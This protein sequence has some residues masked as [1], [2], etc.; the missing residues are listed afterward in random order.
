MQL[1][2]AHEMQQMDGRT[3]EAFGLPGRVLMENAG[4]G[5]VAYFARVFGDLNTKRVGVLAGRGNNGGDGFVMARYLA[6]QGVA[7]TVFLLSA[8]DRLQ[9]D[10]LTNLDLLTPLN[11]PVLE[12]PDADELKHRLPTLNAQ[13]IIIDALLGTGLNSDVRGF[14]KDV[15][16]WLNSRDKPVFAVDIPSGINADTGRICGVAV[17]ATATATFAFAKIGHWIYPGAAHCGA[18]YIVDIGIPPHIAAEVG[19]RQVG[20]TIRDV[21]SL[22][23]PRPM[24][25]HKGTTG[26]MLVVAGSPGKTGAAAMTATAALRVGAGLVTLAVPKGIHPV[27]ETLAVEAMTTEL[28]QTAQ[29]AL[30]EKA[31]AKVLA[32][33]EEK[34]CLAVGPGIGTTAATCRLVRELIT[35]C[36]VPMVIDADGL[37]CIAGQTEVLRQATAPVLLTPHPGEMARLC[38]TTNAAIQQDRVGAARKLATANKA[39]VVLKG[40]RT[41]IA[42]PDGQVVINPT[43]NPGMAAG[44]MG[45]VLTGAIAGLIT[46]GLSLSAAATTGVYLHG[47]AADTLVEQIGPWGFTATEVMDRLPVEIGKLMVPAQPEADPLFQF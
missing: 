8:K 43:G 30:D 23:K 2:S 38:N 40:A 25:A 46:Q 10:A 45:D 13:D 15:I 34:R 3:I 33:A 22:L 5:A 14:F 26:H 32:L 4:R 18:L 19:C 31:L 6:H 24:D 11:V 29:G 20:T 12:I 28:P 7:V 17:Q 1:V 27:V 9:G 21:R 44:G 36:P 42:H 35:K 47:A 37:N 39:H 16:T 41:I